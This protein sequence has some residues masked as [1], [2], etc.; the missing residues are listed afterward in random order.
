ML[1]LVCRCIILPGFQLFPVKVIDF[2]GGIITASF[3]VF[4]VCLIGHDNRK[5]MDILCGNGIVF[6]D[7]SAVVSGPGD[8]DYGRLAPPAVMLLLYLSV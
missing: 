1:R 6:R 7:A 5:L 2:R 8:F 4:P 3:F